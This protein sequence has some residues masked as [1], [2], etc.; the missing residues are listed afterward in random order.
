[1]TSADKLRC[2]TCHKDYAAADA[3]VHTRLARFAGWCICQDCVDIYH[4]RKETGK[5]GE[6]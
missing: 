2:M 3:V 5:S 6:H 1:V 4:K